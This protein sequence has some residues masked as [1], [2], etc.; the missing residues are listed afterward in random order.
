MS[1]KVGAIREKTAV[2]GRVLQLVRRLPR[3]FKGLSWL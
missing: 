2:F 3:L 1:S